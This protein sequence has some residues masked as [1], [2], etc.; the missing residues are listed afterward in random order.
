MDGLATD[1]L[2]HA[3]MPPRKKPVRR[4]KAAPASVG[5]TTAETRQTGGADID[6]KA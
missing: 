1:R 5:L 6:R 2:Y 4:K 3:L